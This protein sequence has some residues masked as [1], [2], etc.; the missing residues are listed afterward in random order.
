MK[1]ILSIINTNTA[2]NL[3]LSAHIFRLPLPVCHPASQYRSSEFRFPVSRFR[4]ISPVTG[5]GV[6]GFSATDWKALM[7]VLMH[8][9]GFLV[10]IKSFSVFFSL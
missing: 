4:S 7:C 2:L 10:R 8:R 6:G 3:R 5:V 9:G 1:I